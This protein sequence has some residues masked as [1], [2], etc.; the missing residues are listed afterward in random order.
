MYSTE[1]EKRSCE[2][3]C[4]YIYRKKSRVSRKTGGASRYED[5]SETCTRS[6]P[7]EDSSSEMDPP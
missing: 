5:G 2:R 6:P 3:T 1:Q 7:N 4:F